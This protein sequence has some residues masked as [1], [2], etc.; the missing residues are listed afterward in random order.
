[1]SKWIVGLPKVPLLNSNPLPGILYHAQD[2]L[3]YHPELPAHSRVFVPVPTMYRLPYESVNIKVSEGIT[4]HAFWIYHP[5]ERSVHL[6]TVVYFHGNA[7][8]MGHRLQNA[9]GIYH[10]L[11]CNVL[12]VEY[13]GYGLSSGEPSETGFYS[14]GRA[15][16]D[17]LLTRHDLDQSQIIL[18][19]RSLG[20]AVAIDVAADPVYGQ[21]IMCVIVENT[22]TSIPDMAV[23]LIHPSVKYLPLICYRNQ[24]MSLHKA[25]FMAAPCLFV[26]GLAD[27]LVPPR[28]MSMLHSRCGSIHKQMLQITGGSHNDTWAVNG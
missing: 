7:G 16:I 17:Y 22:F 18:F 19:G 4:L 25:H 27:A 10:T 11:Q 26:S 13:R 15:A 28:M 14:D 24:Y 2:H 8:N 1:M 12:L 23:E 3:L 9:F 6:P 20:G 21:K 5:P